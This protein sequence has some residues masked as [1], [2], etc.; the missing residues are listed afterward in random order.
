MRLEIDSIE[1]IVNVIR[2]IQLHVSHCIKHEH[3]IN[4]RQNNLEKDEKSIVSPTKKF[5]NCVE[6]LLE[7]L[8]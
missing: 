3:I 7:K 5:Q 2:S 8:F 4:T 1:L 6:N